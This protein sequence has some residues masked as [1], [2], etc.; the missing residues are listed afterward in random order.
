[1][2]T[3]DKEQYIA[4]MVELARLKTT[5]SEL[6]VV[7]DV[8]RFFSEACKRAGLPHTFSP[9][10]GKVIV[11][12]FFEDLGNALF[13]SEDIKLIKTTARVLREVGHGR[14]AKKD[15]DRTAEAYKTWATVSKSNPA[16]ALAFFGS[17]TSRNHPIL[18]VF[19]TEK[20]RIETS[21]SNYE[22]RTGR[23]SDESLKLTVTDAP[24]I[25]QSSAMDYATNA[26]GFLD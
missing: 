9:G 8:Y 17:E 14:Q 1:M 18:A 5:G 16:N 13:A 21:V 20:K 7:V 10:D 12:R 22:K 2:R 25:S 19:A 11:A 3:D 4:A 26:A 6:P 24:R 23:F 15:G